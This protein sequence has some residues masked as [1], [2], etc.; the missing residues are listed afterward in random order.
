ML[1]FCILPTRC[2]R[3]GHFAGTDPV[4]VSQGR[5]PTIPSGV[6]DL[7]YCGAGFFASRAL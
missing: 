4:L 1:N 7:V 2:A 5:W 3:G 6:C